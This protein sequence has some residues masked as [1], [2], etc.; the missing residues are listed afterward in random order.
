MFIVNYGKL[1]RPPPLVKYSLEF[2]SLFDFPA[3]FTGKI[4]IFKVKSPFF[5]AKLIYMLKIGGLVLTPCTSIGQSNRSDLEIQHYR[6]P[7]FALHLDYAHQSSSSNLKSFCLAYLNHHA[8]TQQYRLA[9]IWSHLKLSVP[10]FFPT[11]HQHVCSNKP[12]P[13]I[14]QLVLAIP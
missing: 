12:Y 3:I 8:L 1:E 4:V 14:A 13:H 9:P 6:R 11:H 7:S 5:L 2:V 10:T